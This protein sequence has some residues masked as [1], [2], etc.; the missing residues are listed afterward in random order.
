MLAWIE[1]TGADHNLTSVL[2]ALSGTVITRCYD[3]L[4]T[5]APPHLDHDL[6]PFALESEH[7]SSPSREPSRSSR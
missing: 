1:G 6:S 5:L 4:Q 2:V 7:Q 3:T